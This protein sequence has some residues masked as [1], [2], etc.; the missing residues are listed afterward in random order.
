M[1]LLSYPHAKS[2]K[3]YKNSYNFIVFYYFLIPRSENMHTNKTAK[4]LAIALGEIRVACNVRPVQ[5]CLVRA[6]TVFRSA[7]VVV[8]PVHSG[9]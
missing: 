9:R 2:V 7:E 6:V 3:H 5:T 4:S 8:R 1:L